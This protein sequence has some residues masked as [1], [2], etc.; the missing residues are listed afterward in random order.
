[1]SIARQF[2]R[3]SSA[4]VNWFVHDLLEGEHNSIPSQWGL[5]ELAWPPVNAGAYSFEP[6]PIHIVPY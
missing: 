3:R 2:D 5:G 1:M 6:A 4:D